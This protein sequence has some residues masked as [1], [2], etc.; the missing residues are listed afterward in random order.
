M[1]HRTAPRL[2]VVVDVD[3]EAIGYALDPRLW[4]AFWAALA[5][6]EQEAARWT[7]EA[8]VADLGPAEARPGD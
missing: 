3:D 4:A 6:A 2:V 1:T 7:A 5:P 8:A